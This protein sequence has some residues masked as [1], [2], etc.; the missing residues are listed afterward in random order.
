MSENPAV[1][2]F[3]FG[4]SI[5][6]GI[7]AIALRTSMTPPSEVRAEAVKAGVAEYYVPKGETEPVFRWLP[8]PP[9]LEAPDVPDA[10]TR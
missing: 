6:L 7:L 4:L 1:P 2:A 10:A 9:A 8:P 5:G 3:I